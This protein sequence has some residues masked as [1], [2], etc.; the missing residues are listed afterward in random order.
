MEEHKKKIA[1]IMDGGIV[2][3]TEK[4]LTQMLRKINTDRYEISLFTNVQGNPCI[5]QIPEC[6]KVFDLDDLNLRTH[7]FRALQRGALFKAAQ[8][9]RCYIKLRLSKDYYE[10]IRWSINPFLLSEEMFDCA[11]AYKQSWKTVFLTQNRI[12]SKRKVVWIHGN[13]WGDEQMI[14]ENL[15]NIGKADKVFCV[16][17]DTSKYI[18]NICPEVLGRTEILYNLLDDNE[19]IEKAGEGIDFGS[20]IALVTVGRLTDEKGQIMIPQTVRFLKDAGYQIKWYIV[21]DG[22][23]R[24]KIEQLCQELDVEDRVIFTGTLSNPYPY[25]KSCD[26]YVQTSYSEGYCTTTME[27]KILGKPIVTTDAPGMREQFVNGVNGLIVESMTPAALFM[28]I[29]SLLDNP[30][31]CAQFTEELKKESHDNTQELEKL[32]AFIES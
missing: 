5:G 9:L 1:F 32:Y 15:K 8:L 20:E 13:L 3:G 26:I 19:I 21:G 12:Q 27:A 11:I 6:I 4:A 31:L 16:S 10:Q 23:W 14:S 2:G 30:T 18:E 7:F 25:I 17:A 28:G 24:K 29:K 22:G